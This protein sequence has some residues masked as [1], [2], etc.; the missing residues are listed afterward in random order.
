MLQVAS[1]SQCAQRSFALGQQVPSAAGDQ[2]PH[3]VVVECPPRLV[4]AGD[5]HPD[6]AGRAVDDRRDH[7]TRTVLGISRDHHHRLRPAEDRRPRVRH[8]GDFGFGQRL[9]IPLTQH[10]GR[11]F[12][13]FGV[14][15]DGLAAYARPCC[16][17]K[18]R[19]QRLPTT[20]TEVFGVIGRE[21]QDRAAKSI[22]RH[23]PQE[24]LAEVQ[25]ECPAGRRRR[26]AGA[27][28]PRPHEDDE[29]RREAPRSSHRGREQARPPIGAA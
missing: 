9:A 16:P 25:G 12:E 19:P 15:S 13:R 1:V 3:E 4:G 11:R 7:G 24:P 17:P 8:F 23:D 26:E 22:L 29:E 27:L 14:V 28:R 2:N 10:L 20:A 18:V 5:G 21:Q 6:E